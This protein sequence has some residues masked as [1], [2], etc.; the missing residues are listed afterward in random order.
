MTTPSPKPTCPTCGRMPSERR[1]ILSQNVYRHVLLV[2]DPCPDP[3]HDLADRLVAEHALIRARDEERGKILDSMASGKI[4]LPHNERVRLV[5]EQIKH[6]TPRASESDALR[7]ATSRYAA[8][9]DAVQALSDLWDDAPGR[10]HADT[11]RWAERTI[12][13]LRAEI[14]NLTLAA[15]AQERES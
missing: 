12:K 2:T 9:A 14:A 1:G 3:I 13:R 7:E 10:S 6:A 15:R 5:N 4:D 8:T 11:I